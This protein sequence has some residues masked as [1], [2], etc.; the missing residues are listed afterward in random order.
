MSKK[1]KP[2]AQ[3][4]QPEQGPPMIPEFDYRVWT[5]PYE[6]YDEVAKEITEYLNQKS[7][8]GWGLQGPPRE[9]FLE[10]KIIVAVTFARAKERKVLGPVGLA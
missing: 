8:E 9:A 1:R 4:P 3:S 2:F 7:L 10:D 6:G 5:I